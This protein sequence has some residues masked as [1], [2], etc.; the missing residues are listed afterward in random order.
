MNFFTISAL[1]I[2]IISN[3]KWLIKN[4]PNILMR[5]HNRP[6]TEKVESQTIS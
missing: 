5:H 3:K 2:F 6:V 1:D 4:N